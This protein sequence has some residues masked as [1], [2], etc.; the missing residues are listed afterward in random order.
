MFLFFSALCTEKDAKTRGDVWI[1]ARHIRSCLSKSLH[2]YLVHSDLVLVSH[3][4]AFLAVYRRRKIP[5]HFVQIARNRS[6]RFIRVAGHFAKS[7]IISPPTSL[8]R[9][10]LVRLTSLSFLLPPLSRSPARH[11]FLAGISGAFHFARSLSR[12]FF[13]FLLWSTSLFSR[14]G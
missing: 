3:G 5:S 10:L 2:S 14:P 1:I 9:G 7:R 8:V 13:A 11:C 12:T 4:D 6:E